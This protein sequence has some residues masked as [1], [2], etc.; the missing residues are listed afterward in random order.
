[1]QVHFGYEFGLGCDRLEM[2]LDGNTKA[3][4]GKSGARPSAP[5]R[6]TPGFDT[7]LYVHGDPRANLLLDIALALEERHHHASDA[8]QV[9]TK[10]FPSVQTRT[11]LCEALVVLSQALG[12]PYQA[13]G[14]LLALARSAGCIAHVLEQRAQNSI[15]RPRGK[16]VGA[17][18]NSPV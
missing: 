12:L 16:F 9:I 1:L 4:S 17:P 15:I 14:G 3:K 7:P 8:L 5:S 13:A 2:L 11:N 10:H 6:T 18:A